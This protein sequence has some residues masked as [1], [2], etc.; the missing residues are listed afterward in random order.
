MI[1]FIHYI[2]YL[3]LQKGTAAGLAD[4]AFEMIDTSHN[5]NLMFS[6][7]IKFVASD[8]SPFI[9]F[10]LFVFLGV[11]WLTRE[12]TYRGYCYTVTPAPYMGG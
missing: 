4:V 8:T 2:I 12:D 11:F 7:F 3:H 1:I 9:H 6:E 5:G 10:V